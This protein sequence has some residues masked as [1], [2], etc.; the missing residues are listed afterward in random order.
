MPF[1][2]DS[3][4]PLNPMLAAEIAIGCSEKL[5]SGAGKFA[6]FERGPAWMPIEL[7]GKNW[8]ASCNSQR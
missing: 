4:N 5:N 8:H 2:I 6:V 1:T 3:Q 7:G